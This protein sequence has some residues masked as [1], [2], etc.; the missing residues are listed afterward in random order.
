MSATLH[1]TEHAFRRAK[2]RLGL[3]RS[4]TERMAART[5]SEGVRHNEV[6][7]AL[8]SFL[9]DVFLSRR[10]ADNARVY[11]EIVWVFSGHSLL[12]VLWVPLDLRA[13]ARRAMRARAGTAEVCQ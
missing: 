2:E 7:G 5:F 9:D 10:T 6:A 4:A 3:S 1:I 13:A 12:T 11:G 8:K